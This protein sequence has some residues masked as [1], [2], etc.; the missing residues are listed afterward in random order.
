MNIDASN[1]VINILSIQNSADHAIHN[2][3]ASN[4]IVWTV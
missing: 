4:N 2:Q 1:I 3:T